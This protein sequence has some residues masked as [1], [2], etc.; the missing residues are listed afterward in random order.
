MA[1]THRDNRSVA[2]DP[3][4]SP[5]RAADGRRDTGDGQNGDGQ[6][7]GRN[8]YGVQV[9]GGVVHGDVAG[10]YRAEVRI[11]H[12]RPPAPVQAR[13]SLAEAAAALR[14]EL[15]RLRTD[16]PAEIGEADAADAERALADIE[17]AAAEEQPQQSVL[18]RRIATV[19]DA[20][21]GVSA[22]AAAV[23]AVQAAFA[24]LFPGG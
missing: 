13:A 15:S 20:L 22:V 4:P 5:A 7:G 1:G 6:N 8:N 14:A 16:R 9:T 2:P 3:L 18:R 24:A 11:T 19:V 12:D 23:T 10:G 21:Q 17:S